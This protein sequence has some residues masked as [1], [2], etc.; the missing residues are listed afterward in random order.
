MKV[1]QRM[2]KLLEQ[3]INGDKS[4]EEKIFQTILER[5]HLFAR[6]KI[7][8]NNAAKDVAQEA[9]LIVLEKYKSAT[10]SIGFEAWAY[11]VLKMRIRN[12]FYGGVGG[13]DRPGPSSQQINTYEDTPYDIDPDLDL[14]LNRCLRKIITVKP[15]YARVLNLVYQG[16]K[17][18]EICA[19][20]KISRNNVYVTLNRARIL[21]KNCL[22]SGEV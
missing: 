9:C 11:G 12:Y 17:A 2:E 6:H 22:E 14:Q 3:A 4:A 13:R 16:Y 19:R 21:L 8:D 15:L 7:G 10:F 1:T 18:D 5:F 20:L